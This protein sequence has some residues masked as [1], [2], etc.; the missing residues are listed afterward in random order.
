[1]H[2]FTYALIMLHTDLHKPELIE[3]MPIE[4]FIKQ[5]SKVNDGGNFSEE[6]LVKCYNDLRDMEYKT[7]VTRDLREEEKIP[8]GNLI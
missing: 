7:L 2:T 6:F 3:K 4:K 5:V 8:R 1:M